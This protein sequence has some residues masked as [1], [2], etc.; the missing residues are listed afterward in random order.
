MA[1]RSLLSYHF[2]TCLVYAYIKSTNEDDIRNVLYVNVFG[3][4]QEGI[5]PSADPWKGSMLPLHHWRMSS[6][7]TDLTLT[8]I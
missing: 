8:N 6:L 4:R 2:A 1:E 7:A 3:V 5:G